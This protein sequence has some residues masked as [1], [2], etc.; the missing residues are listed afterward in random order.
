MLICAPFHSIS[1][2]P[3]GMA[4]LSSYLESQG[5]PCPMRDL[6]IEARAYIES[7]GFSKEQME[8]F[9]SLARR[10]YLAEAV[11]WSWHHPDGAE[12]IV[13]QAL[14]KPEI[15]RKFWIE[16]IGV[17]RIIS[18]P[19]V[20]RLGEH[21]RDWLDD[22]ALA[23]AQDT[24][25]E[26]LGFSCVITNLPITL[27]LSQKIRQ[28]RDD[29]LIL[30][31]GAHLSHRNAFQLLE[32]FAYIDATI[33]APAYHA[34][35]TL[36]H[37]RV[38]NS[39]GPI[40]PGVWRRRR[41]RVGATADDET[42][43][44]NSTPEKLDMNALPPANWSYL[45]MNAYESGFMLMGPQGTDFSKWYPTIPIQTS[46]GCSYSKCRFC[47]NVVD[48]PAYAMR[49]PEV[50]AADIRHQ[51]EQIGSKGFFFTDDEFTGSAKRVMEIC[52]LLRE[53]SQDIRFSLWMRLDAVEEAL[54]EAMYAAGGRQFF[55]GVEA[56]DN[57]LLKLMAKGYGSKEALRRLDVLYQFG[58]R[59]PDVIYAYNL[60]INYPGETLESVQNTFQHVA[61]NPHLFVGSLSACCEFHIYEGT[62]AYYKH[63]ENAEGCL[64]TL[65]PP[66]VA[67]PSFR[68]LLPN[69]DLK[70]WPERR[71]IWKAI[72]DMARF[73][74]TRDALEETANTT[75]IY[76]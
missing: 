23:I 51:I 10:T 34:L 55:I 1:N 58:Q 4:Y 18:D 32:N 45:D 65:L 72:G 64:D 22:K 62:P 19:E 25:L 2:A 15:M 11:A 12:G 7:Q 9:F 75:S 28:R 3:V 71:Q 31:G 59:H 47:H 27:Y 54:L 17:E 49:R 41:H 53:I 35:A 30:M 70:T 74:G 43:E 6:N 16:D 13:H 42:I 38:S 46:R 63:A 52:D 40:P 39:Q 68:Y 67:M 57:H 29:L 33:P 69:H 50:V 37:Y 5:I 26:W 14:A 56:V 8:A 20:R 66:G 60:I 61:E 21:L 48:Y 36:I 76:T 24:S 73:K 44:Y